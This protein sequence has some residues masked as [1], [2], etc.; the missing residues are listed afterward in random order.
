MQNASSVEV[1]KIKGME[2]ELV[3][4]EGRTSKFD[5]L[6]G[7]EELRGDMAGVVEYSTALFERET[8]ERMMGHFKNLLESIVRGSEVGIGELEMLREEE[9]REIVEEWNRT[10]VEYPREKCVHELFEEQAER[11]PEAVAVEYE[12]K[13]MSYGELNERA[14]QVGHYLRR[15]G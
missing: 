8:I 4:W 2:F 9:R 12:G 10:V 13:E 5:M 1:I 14:N 15:L 11:S 6:V 3:E 7:L